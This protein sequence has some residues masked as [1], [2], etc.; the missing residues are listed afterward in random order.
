MGI[1]REKEDDIVRDPLAFNEKGEIICIGEV[2]PNTVLHVLKGHPDSLL[3]AAQK[4][5]KDCGASPEQ[6]IIAESTF[7]VE[8]ITRNLFLGEQFAKEIDFIHESLVIQN[9]TQEPYGVL[10]LGEIASYGDGLLELF[11]KTIVVGIYP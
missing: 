4:A 1:F 2:R 10:S 9:Q 6:P 8:C 11:N 7:I 5:V 3:F